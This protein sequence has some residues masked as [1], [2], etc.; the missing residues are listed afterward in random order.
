M[1]V[2]ADGQF[3][4]MSDLGVTPT[5][6]TINMMTGQEE[7]VDPPVVWDE[8]TN[9]PAPLTS[10]QKPSLV[11]RS[12]VNGIPVSL[13]YDMVKQAISEYPVEKASEYSGVSPDEIKELARTYAEDGPVSTFIM[14]GPD[15]Y[16][17][18][19]YNYWPMYAVCFHRQHRKA[20]RGSWIYHEHGIVFR[21][22]HSGK[23]ARG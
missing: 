18:G 5:E 7:P 11:S 14:F 20:R 2:K 8:A 15:H 22:W 13:V 1:F 3:L 10:A 23:H 21:R 17:N 9:A 19:H 6:T 16:L 4:R 12:D